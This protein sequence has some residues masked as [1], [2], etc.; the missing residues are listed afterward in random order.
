MDMIEFDVILGM[1]WLT[2]HRVIIVGE[3]LPTHEME[4]MLCFRGISIILYPRLCM[5]PGGTD[6]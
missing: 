5:T 4:F 1:A 3:L 6:S 2:A